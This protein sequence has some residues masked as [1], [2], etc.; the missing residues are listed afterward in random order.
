M[1][2]ELEDTT[3]VVSPLVSQEHNGNASALKEDGGPNKL[4]G[5]LH[6]FFYFLFIIFFVLENSIYTNTASLTNNWFVIIKCIVVSGC[7]IAFAKLNRQ[8]KL[9]QSNFS[10]S[11]SLGI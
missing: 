11:F 5:F 9:F 2:K 6:L 7:C 3:A 4:D 8:V 1:A 10:N